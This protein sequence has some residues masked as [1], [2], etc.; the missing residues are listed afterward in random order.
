MACLAFHGKGCNNILFEPYSA[1]QGCNKVRWPPGQEAS[2][3]HPWSKLLRSFGSK[4]TVLNWLLKKV[5]VTSL[6]LFSA[7]HTYSFPPAVILCPG[8]YAP[9]VMPLLLILL[10]W[11]CDSP[12]TG[13]ARWPTPIYMWCE[14]AIIKWLQR[15]ISIVACCHSVK[16]CALAARA[17]QSQQNGAVT[18]M[19]RSCQVQPSQKER[20]VCCKR[21]GCCYNLSVGIALNIWFT[22]NGICAKTNTHICVTRT[23][24]N[25]V[26]VAHDLF[27]CLLP[28][29]EAF[30]TCHSGFLITTI[31]SAWLHSYNSYEYYIPTDL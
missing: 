30:C 26:I 9:L 25:R 4:C 14:Q 2:L 3:V 27:C 18:R 19:W 6:G 16:L 8:N 17:F 13:C 12:R 23:S 20:A 21:R 22:T 11:I 15:M 29:C 7:S 5:L 10:R 1:N 28:Q 24:N 31:P